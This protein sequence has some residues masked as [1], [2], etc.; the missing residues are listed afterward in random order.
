MFKFTNDSPFIQLDNRKNREWN[1]SSANNHN[2]RFSAM[3]PP[4]I[5]AGNSVLDLGA[6]IGAAGE[7]CM[8]NGAYSY[9]AVELSDEYVNTMQQILT[10]RNVSIINMDIEEFLETN[11][12]KFDVVILSG[13][14]YGF[15]DYYNLFKRATN[16]ANKYLCLDLTRPKGAGD[17]EYA[18]ALM[19]TA[20]GVFETHGP[21]ISPD[22]LTFLL[23]TL[24]FGCH[25]QTLA[26]PN[27]IP[28]GIYNSR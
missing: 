22:T 16:I 20:E 7:W 26:L 21:R 17:I 4:D 11:E 12:E 13:V 2:E 10:Y 18:R 1:P 3:L 24:N 25:S 15:I 14:V 8:Q 6:C 5:I 9:T 23:S 28:N 27:Y 19:T